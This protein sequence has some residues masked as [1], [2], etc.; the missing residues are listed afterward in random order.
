MN[1]QKTE[2]PD[3][4]IAEPR[5][6]RDSR[7][8]FMESFNAKKYEEAGIVG[9]FVQDNHSYSCK[10]TLRGLHAQREFPQGKLV[11]CV[12]GEIWDVA[13][14]VRR[15]S[16][17]FGKWVGVTLT[18]ENCHQLWVPPGFV[19]GFCVLSATAQVEYKVTEYYHPEDELGVIWNDPTI[20]IDWP[21]KEPV[22]SQKDAESQ[23][24]EEVMD[25]L[26]EFE[27]TT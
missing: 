10:D 27:A 6:F 20:A 14:D 15:G 7:G 3:V 5:V 23:T 16:P 12:E 18:A 8:F 19:H 11:R 24:L 25:L 9:P 22:L 1:F 21:V 26:P 2:I 4:V 13:V 17:T